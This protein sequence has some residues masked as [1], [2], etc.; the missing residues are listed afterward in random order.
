MLEKVEKSRKK[1]NAFVH[2][3]SVIEADD[4]GG[5]IRTATDLMTNLMEIRV[6]SQ[7]SISFWL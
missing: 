2:N 4:A 7:L 6:T 1:R 5:A 3:L